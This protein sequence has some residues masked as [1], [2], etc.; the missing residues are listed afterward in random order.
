MI[1]IMLIKLNFLFAD[2][3]LLDIQPI[4]QLSVAVL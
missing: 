1:W 4:T 3:H 2:P